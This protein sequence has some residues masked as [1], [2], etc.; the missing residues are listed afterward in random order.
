MNRL[1]D[2]FQEILQKMGL[3]P[4]KKLLVAFS[5]GSDS[6]VLVHL[7]SKTR[8]PFALAHVNYGLRGVES[9]AD[10]VFCVET[11]AALNCNIHVLNKK[12]IV[13]NYKQEFGVSTQQAAR[14]IRYRWFQ[15]LCKTYEYDAILTAHNKNDHVETILINLVRGTG[16][17]G[18]CGIPAVSGNIYRPLLTFSKDDLDAYADENNIKFRTDSSNMESH[19]LRNV[20]RNVV[21]PSINELKPGFVQSIAE[22]IPNY[23]FAE[24]CVNEFVQRFSNENMTNEGNSIQIRGEAIHN[25]PF[26]SRIL[27]QLIDNY[28]FNHAQCQAIVNS[29]ENGTGKI[30]E[31]QDFVALINRKNIILRPKQNKIKVSSIFIQQDTKNIQAP[32]HLQLSTTQE[33][34]DFSKIDTFTAYF[35]FDRLKFP[36]E[37]RKIQPGDKMIPYGMKG[38]KKISDIFIDDKVDR[39]SKGEVFVLVSDNEII[40]L[41][42]HRTSEIAKITNDTQKLLKIIF[43]PKV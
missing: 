12:S 5:G 38:H 11:A 6:S 34:P 3:D 17:K 23:S 2:R 21:I 8:I 39:I 30:F 24:Y 43:L 37:V 19:Y 35:D 9:D 42:G 15:Q 41:I 40:W 25:H 22:N 16:I 28:G 13:E 18:L 1:P 29:I 20:I 32:I 10:E 4:A 27:Y 14:E 26:G 7:L 36:L 33:Q 31:S